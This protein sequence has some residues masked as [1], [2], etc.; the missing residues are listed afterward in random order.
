MPTRLRTKLA[1]HGSNRA[2]PALSA[3]C[4]GV[5]G[6]LAAAGAG[7]AT[8]VQAGRPLSDTPKLQ[9][10]IDGVV[11]AGAPGV[12]V[13]ARDGDRTV[14]L[15]SGFSNLTPRTPMRVSD[16]FRVGSLTKT[17]VATVVLQLVGERKL[18]LTDTVEHWL[19]GLVPNGDK[20]ILRELLNHTSGLAE[21][22]DAALE[23]KIASNPTKAWTPRQLI[24]HATAKKP[25][26]AP[27]ARWSYSNTGY[28]LAGLIVEKATG[29]SLGAELQRRIFDPLQLRATSYD[30]SPRI[31]GHHADGY[32]LVGKPPVKD[33][34]ILTPT[35]AGAAGA[36]VSTADDVARFERALL[37]G[38]LL[39]PDLLRAMQTTVPMGFPGND[40][41][42]GLWRTG[43]LAITPTLRLPCG[44]VWGHNG[45]F[46]GYLTNAFASKDGTHQLVVL[47]NTDVP[48]RPFL[49]ALARLVTTAYCG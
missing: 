15:A 23:A 33:V 10:A 28:V 46:L 9:A 22:D 31:A 20:I 30:S 7:T 2:G 38:R 40:Y 47:V 45:D 42:L 36:I 35:W 17:F 19:P 29:H 41:G 14:R 11:A 32:G 25:D 18:S 21:Y 49:Q 39:R 26:F 13:L 24:A 3:I 5:F 37:Q 12:V 34:S 6:L 1:A 4:L 43:T 8:A 27:G 16:R 44:V 48:S